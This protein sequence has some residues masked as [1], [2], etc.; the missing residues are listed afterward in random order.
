MLDL[1]RI[2]LL[3]AFRRGVVLAQNVLELFPVDLTAFVGVEFV[4][5]LLY[6]L[7]HVLRLFRG[8]FLTHLGEIDREIDCAQRLLWSK[9]D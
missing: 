8:H 6:C 4:E 7:L 1:R 5:G 3:L 2:H 9:T